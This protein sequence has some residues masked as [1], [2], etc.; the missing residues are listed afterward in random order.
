MLLFISPGL[1]KMFVFT[2]TFLCNKC[3]VNLEVASH[4]ARITILGTICLSQH[5]ND[6]F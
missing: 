3:I 2:A 4:F 1:E 6:T 5:P